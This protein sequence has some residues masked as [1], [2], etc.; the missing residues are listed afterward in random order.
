LRLRRFVGRQTVPKRP[1]AARAATLHQI[2]R[3][4]TAGRE[5]NTPC[6]GADHSGLGRY[7]VREPWVVLGAG[8]P[9]LTSGA[10]RLINAGWALL[11]V[12]A[13]VGGDIG[14]GVKDVVF[15]YQEIG[16]STPI[17]PRSTLVTAQLFV[18][19]TSHDAIEAECRGDTAIMPRAE[20]LGRPVTRRLIEIGWT[21]RIF[22]WTQVL[23]AASAHP[24]S[25]FP[26][27]IGN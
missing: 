18:H 3:P 10:E 14:K 5:D 22:K 6:D 20:S 13:Q 24:A 21:G 9:A 17:D 1:T 16:V 12:T 7:G 11:L 19:G 23:P 15:Q 25:P 27:R 4:S 8:A 2:P 26:L